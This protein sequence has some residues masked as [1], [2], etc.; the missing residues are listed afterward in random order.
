V[1]PS[2][3]PKDFFSTYLCQNITALEFADLG[4]D[5]RLMEGIGSSGY[6]VATPV[7]EQVIPLVLQGKD[8]IAFA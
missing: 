1:Q 6:R 2:E 5:E 8:V 3:Q 7:Q 4:F